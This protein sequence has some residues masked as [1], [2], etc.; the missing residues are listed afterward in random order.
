M[1]PGLNLSVGCSIFSEGMG[2]AWSLERDRRY[3]GA[4]EAVPVCAIRAPRNMKHVS[5]A[6]APNG[7]D[8]RNAGTEV[9]AYL[10]I[11]M[12]RICGR[13]PHLSRIQ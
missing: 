3:C 7:S 9:P 5:G 11:G 10:G 12:I 8:G 1:T 4:P 6:K 13:L 2:S